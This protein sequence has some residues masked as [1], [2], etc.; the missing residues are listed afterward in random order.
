MIA[1]PRQPYLTSAQYLQMEEQSNIKY[2]YVDGQILAMAGECDAHVTIAG[3]LFTLLR[4]HVRGSNCR[5]YISDIK[6]PIESR[7]AVLLS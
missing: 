6:A 1:S 4:S 3:N 2:E 5:V 7:I